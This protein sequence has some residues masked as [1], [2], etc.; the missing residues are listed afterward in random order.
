MCVSEDTFQSDKLVLTRSLSSRWR[1]PMKRRYLPSS[2]VWDDDVM[3]SLVVCSCS[4]VRKLSTGPSCWTSATR[5]LWRTASTIASSLATWTWSRWTTAT[6]TIATTSRGTS[7][8]PWTSLVS[9][10]AMVGDF[11]RVIMA[12]SCSLFM[13]VV[14]LHRVADVWVV[15]PADWFHS[16]TIIVW[17]KVMPPSHRPIFS[18]I[19]F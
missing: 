1:M 18:N 9:G 12:L 5:R 10:E 17:K 14:L 8:S 6:S 13:L 7:P 3:V 16:F 11:C 4:W 19:A 2:S 15:W